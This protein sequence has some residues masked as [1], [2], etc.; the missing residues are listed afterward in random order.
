MQRMQLPSFI[1]F[2]LSSLFCLWKKLLLFHHLR[3]WS[4]WV[5]TFFPVEDDWND[6]PVIVEL[7]FFSPGK[8]FSSLSGKHN[9]ISKGYYTVDRAVAD[10][11]RGPGFESSHRQLLL[12]IDLLIPEFR[13]DEKRNRGREWP[14]KQF[15]LFPFSNKSWFAPNSWCVL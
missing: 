1:L 4:W 13:K 12:N 7:A 14:I 10:D 3:M 9:T 11:P 2:Y 15:K 5:S 6:L 8:N